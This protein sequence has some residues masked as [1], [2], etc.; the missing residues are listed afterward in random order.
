[1]D[2][3][4]IINAGSS[5]LKF[6]VF[7]GKERVL[8]GSIEEIAT[9]AST[10][11]V[12]GNT[13]EFSC[14]SFTEG[15]SKISELLLEHSITP[16]RIGYRV[17]FGG[18]AFTR[19]TVIDESIL[20]MLSSLTP[21]APLHMPQEIEIIQQFRTQFPKS[22]HFASFDTSFHAAIPELAKHSSLPYAFFDEGVQRYG[23]HGLS[24]EYI[25]KQK[26]GMHGRILV[27][28]LGSGSSVCALKDGRSIDTSMGLTPLGGVPMCTRSGDLDPGIL[29]YL[30]RKGMTREEVEQLLEK[31]SGLLGMSGISKDMRELLKSDLPKAKIAVDY[32]C[33]EV[34]KKMSSYLAP[35]GGV[36]GLVF[37]AGIG[38]RSPE[39]RSKIC[40][41]L[42]FIGVEIDQE[43]NQKNNRIITSP[44]GKVPVYVIPTDEERVIVDHFDEL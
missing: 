30:F 12:N 25:S 11:D 6:S 19:P 34:A 15:V 16:T 40:T 21:F 3:M 14:P 41:Y 43:K 5:S 17:V 4:L 38:E 42:S 2:E 44:H 37:T 29:L 13:S 1:M 35:L 22:I 26:E 33:Y 18:R 39:I 10:L 36:D 7:E 32:F 23:F 28:H 24:Y 31:K 20:Q 9:N 8:T 27:A